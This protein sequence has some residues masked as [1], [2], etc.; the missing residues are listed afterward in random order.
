MCFIDSMVNKFK[1]QKEKLKKNAKR[2]I[3]EFFKLAKESFKDDKKKANMYV[4]KARRVAMKHKIRLPSSIQKRFCKHCYSYLV[5][6]VNCR[7]RTRDGKL[8]YSCLECKKFM[9]FVVKK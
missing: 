5:P 7:V 2:D 6:S 4:R 9:R 8:V 1:I 3:S